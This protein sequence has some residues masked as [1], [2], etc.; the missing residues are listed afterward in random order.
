[1]HGKQRRYS[2]VR[3]YLSVCT[4]HPQR[5]FGES[6]EFDLPQKEKKKVDDKEDKPEILSINSLS[7][8][9]QYSPN[10]NQDFI[11]PSLNSNASLD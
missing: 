4:S 6:L 10:I 2:F 5:H 8:Q 7:A 11:N 1:V 9:G 3:G